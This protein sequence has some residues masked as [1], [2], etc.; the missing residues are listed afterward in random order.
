MPTPMAWVTGESI[1]W[2]MAQP[3]AISATARSRVENI[4]ECSCPASILRASAI[5]ALDNNCVI[6]VRSNYSF[7]CGEGTRLPQSGAKGIGSTS[8]EQSQAYNYCTGTAGD[9]QDEAYSWNSM[10]RGWI[11]RVKQAELLQ[12][13]DEP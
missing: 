9:F 11:W 13:L 6:V 2:N 7:V 5:S 10:N 12:S 4:A 3:P 1:A 8:S